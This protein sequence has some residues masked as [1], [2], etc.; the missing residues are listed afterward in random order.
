M[1]M[2]REVVEDTARKAL[3]FEVTRQDFYAST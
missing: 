2:G 3:A 1:T